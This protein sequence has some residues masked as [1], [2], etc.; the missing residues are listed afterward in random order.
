MGAPW[1]DWRYCEC[2]VNPE[3][4]VILSK[5]D[6]PSNARSVYAQRQPIVRR[7]QN[8]FGIFNS[9]DR[10]R[11]HRRNKLIQLLPSH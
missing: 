11:L 8:Q 1:R 3:N 2:R 7:V 10:Y 5:S 6:L 4:L 9:L